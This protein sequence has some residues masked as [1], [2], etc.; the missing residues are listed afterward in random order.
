[1]L[2]H[3]KKRYVTLIEMLIALAIIAVGAGL[4]GINVNKAV[5]EQR[6]NGEVSLVV[7]QLRLAQNL[8]LI[9]NQDVHVKFR[10]KGGVL[11]CQLD[12]ECP[13]D[14]GWDKELN[15]RP[16]ALNAIRSISLKTSN[17]KLE[18][19]EQGEV[20]LQ[21]MS[22]GTVMSRGVLTLSSSA[23]P[24]SQK[25]EDRAIVLQGF[26]HP[27]SL[28]DSVQPELKEQITFDDKNKA[29]TQYVVHEISAKVEQA[30][31]EA[32]NDADKAPKNEKNQPNPRDNEKRSPK[33]E[34]SNK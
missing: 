30:K 2:K 24:F 29:L 8:M 7:D 5:K 22:G 18:S 20:I 33:R 13:L 27:I 28:S 10:P 23:T 16:T 4:I 25:A 21:F 14:K 31:N 17:G 26:P 15:Q 32:K 6:F 11:T 19:T 3:V 9:L 1:M 12:F 34:D